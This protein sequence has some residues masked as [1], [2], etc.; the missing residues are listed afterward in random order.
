MTEAQASQPA[1]AAPVKKKINRADFMFK[2]KDGETLVKVPGQIDGRA[3]AIRNLENCKVYLY[4]HIAQ[5][6]AGCSLSLAFNSGSTDDLVNFPSTCIDHCR[7]VQQLHVRRGTSQRIH[8]PSRLHQLHSAC[9]LPAV[10][11]P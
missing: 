8:F 7:Q 6:S 10:P 5:V 11:L 2:E 4:D 9:R 1:P 3:F